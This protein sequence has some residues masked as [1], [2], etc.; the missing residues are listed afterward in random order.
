MAEEEGAGEVDGVKCPHGFDGKRLL[1][2]GRHVR[3]DLENSP[4][5]RGLCERGPHLR[6]IGLDKIIEGD[7]AADRA[8]ALDE[9]EPRAG[10]FRGCAKGL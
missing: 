4:A 9:R 3:G 1:C 8:V 5:R 2:A 6:G 7:G 10:D